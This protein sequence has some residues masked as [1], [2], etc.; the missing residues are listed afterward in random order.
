MYAEIQE[1]KENIQGYR[2]TGTVG[3]VPF[4]QRNLTGPFTVSN[5]ASNPS[6]FNLGNASIGQ[7]S[8]DCL[9]QYLI[10]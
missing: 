8:P 7:L 5:K 2:I 6:T 3:D 4:S 10:F 9:F 1:A